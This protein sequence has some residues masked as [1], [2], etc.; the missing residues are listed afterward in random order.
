MTKANICLLASLMLFSSAT[1]GAAETSTRS[2]DPRVAVL[3]WYTVGQFV[4]LENGNLLTIGKNITRVSRDN[5]R[6]WQDQGPITNS[7]PGIPAAG[8]HV[9]QRTHNGALVLVYMDMST[10]NGAWD[11]V[12]GEPLAGMKLDVWA[13][14]SLD[15]GRTWRDKQQLLDGYCGALINIIETRDGHIVVP[16][17][18]TFPHPG[19]SVTMSYVS[20]DRG[21]TWKRS[22]FIDLGGHGDHDGACEASVVELSDGRIFMLMRTC[23]DQFWR[24]ISSDHGQTWL[25]IGPSGIDASSSPSNMIRLASGRIALFWNRLYPEGQRNAPR[26]D[27]P[28]AHRPASWHRAELSMALSDDDCQSWSKPIVLGRD[29]GTGLAYTSIFENKPGE[30]WLGIQLARPPVL[31]SFNEAD[32]AQAGAR[33]AELLQRSPGISR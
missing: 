24:A 23:Y 13:I 28:Y 5:G 7:K 25:E 20:A 14:R 1:I 12:R 3:P 16:A 11:R 10:M 19:R 29:D 21:R 15:D 26:R 2:F 30:I 18:Q 6:T 32:F 33:R 8:S 17:C 27:K 31:I 9:L 22:N 4:R